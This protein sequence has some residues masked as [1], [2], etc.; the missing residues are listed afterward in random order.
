M[1]CAN[2][3][4]WIMVAAIG[5]A[6]ATVGCGDRTPRTPTPTAP[7]QAPTPEPPEVTF[8]PS[9]AAQH[10]LDKPLQKTKFR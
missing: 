6:A 2:I 4:H 3:R 5:L 10:Y 1:K 7:T 8:D 9:T